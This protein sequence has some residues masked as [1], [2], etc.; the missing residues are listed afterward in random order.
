MK[1]KF[2]K[3]FFAFSSALFC[4]L[5][6]VSFCYAQTVYDSVTDEPIEIPDFVESSDFKRVSEQEYLKSFAKSSTA[7][8]QSI[9]A[10]DILDD[11]RFTAYAPTADMPF[12]QYQDFMDL[13]NYEASQGLFNPDLVGSIPADALIKSAYTERAKELVEYANQSTGGAPTPL[14]NAYA[15]IAKRKVF[16]PNSNAYE[17][18]YLYYWQDNNRTKPNLD[19]VSI[20]NFYIQP[21]TAVLCRYNSNG[22]STVTYTTTDQLHL[23]YNTSFNDSPFYFQFPRTGSFSCYNSEG[24][25]E[26]LS[27]DTSAGWFYDPSPV[28]F[29]SSPSVNSI[30]SNFLINAYNANSSR[31]TAGFGDI[32]TN[33]QCFMS[34]SVNPSNH[35]ITL[36]STINSGLINWYMSSYGNFTGTNFVPFSTDTNINAQK[37]PVYNVYNSNTFNSGATLTTQNVNN[38]ADYGITYNNDT[39]EFE[40]DVNALAVGVAAELDAKFKPAFDGVY[41]AQPDIGANFTNNTNNYLDIVEDFAVDLINKQYPPASGWIPPKYPSVNTSAYIPV[42][43]PTIPTATYPQG[44]LESMGDTLT[45]GQDIFDTFGVL[46]II[47]PIVIFLVLWR[48]LGGR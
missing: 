2:L 48:I 31:Y 9:T 30:T 12:D 19:G 15:F 8:Q 41:G 35:R 43:Y 3:R 1:T 7:P 47:I 32:M 46:D 5:L 40:L 13:L 11:S 17:V 10:S 42:T 37:A 22:Y 28:Y 29:V 18:D 21:N 25:I 34:N 27:W 33:A 26:S 38:Y 14:K 36:D 24:T 45:E 16:Y 20:G 6:P 4:F 39:H 23:Y 44:Y